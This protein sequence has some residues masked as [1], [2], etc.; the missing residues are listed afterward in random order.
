LNFKEAREKKKEHFKIETPST[1]INIYHQIFAFVN[2]VLSPTEFK[3][4]IA[5]YYKEKREDFDQEA[6]EFLEDTYGRNWHA[7]G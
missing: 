6:I 5:R 2:Q 7:I 3:P 1:V 4:I